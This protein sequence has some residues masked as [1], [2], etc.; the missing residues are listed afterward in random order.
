MSELF[1]DGAQFDSTLPYGGREEYVDTDRLRHLEAHMLAATIDHILQSSHKMSARTDSVAQST[2][3][4][5]SLSRQLRYSE[6]PADISR[7]LVI[8]VDYTR[9]TNHLTRELYRVAVTQWV[10]TLDLGA[11]SFRNTYD[12]GFHGSNADAVTYLLLEAPDLTDRQGVYQT[13]PLTP[14]DRRY[15]FDILNALTSQIHQHYPHA[16]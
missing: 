8:D 4:D 6:D 1:E 16:S 12:L 11:V 13:R 15:L 3:E 9:T 2:R 7:E 10:Y 5:V 14:Y